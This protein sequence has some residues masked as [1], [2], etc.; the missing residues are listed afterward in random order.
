MGD[1]CPEL[2]SCACYL[3]Y[4]ILSVRCLCFYFLLTLHGYRASH[5]KTKLVCLTLVH[6]SYC[7]YQVGVCNC[8]LVLTIMI[9]VYILCVPTAPS[10]PPSLPLWLMFD[11][12][13]YS[14]T[15]AIHSGHRTYPGCQDFRLW[16]NW[17]VH[18]L[19]STPALK[20]PPPNAQNGAEQHTDECVFISAMRWLSRCEGMSGTSFPGVIHF[21]KGWKHLWVSSTVPP[22]ASCSVLPQSGSPAFSLYISLW[23]PGGGVPLGQQLYTHRFASWP[24]QLLAWVFQE[25]LF[26]EWMN[27]GLCLSPL[28][29]LWW[30]RSFDSRDDL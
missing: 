11:Y 30:H 3:S 23:F 2:L 14:V 17:Q 24:A 9:C 20:F 10:P 25:S 28:H 1:L 16:S 22:E 27:D 5:F 7:V 19:T 12:I 4:V 21:R 26:H 6:R 18:T 15:K 8:F 29:F 13:P